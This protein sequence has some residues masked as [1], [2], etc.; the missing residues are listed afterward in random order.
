[1]CPLICCLKKTKTKKL[2][3]ELIICFLR[4]NICDEM[5]PI[6]NNFK[7]WAQNGKMIF[8]VDD[9]PVQKYLLKGGVKGI[10]A[11]LVKNFFFKS[12]RRKCLDQWSKE[13]STEVDVKKV[14]DCIPKTSKLVSWLVL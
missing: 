4:C 8:A 1:M 2:G 10:Y 13:L 11:R 6:K 12:D 14:F 9:V 3:G 5:L 7:K